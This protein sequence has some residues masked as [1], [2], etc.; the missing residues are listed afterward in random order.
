[1]V[2]RYFTT[3]FQLAENLRFPASNQIRVNIVSLVTGRKRIGRDQR[4]TA[5]EE[6]SI[7]EKIKDR[8]VTIVSMRNVS[9]IKA[10][11]TCYCIGHRF[12]QCLSS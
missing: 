7:D 10:T 12:E 4:N 3:V 11:L 5:E 6:A 9:N 8:S 2:P 1:M